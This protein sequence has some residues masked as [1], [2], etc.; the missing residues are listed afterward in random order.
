MT[1]SD[2]P[3]APHTA[4]P[5]DASMQHPRHRAGPLRLVEDAHLEVDEVDVAQ[6]R[7]DLTDRVAEGACRARGPGR[8]PRPCAQSA[9]RRPR[10]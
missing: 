5:S 8:C 3:I 4:S 6:V 2:T 10:S 7:M 1:F 9:R